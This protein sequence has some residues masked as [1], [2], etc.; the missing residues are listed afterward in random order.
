MGGHT[1]ATGGYVIDCKNLRQ[2]SFDPTT[3]ICVTVH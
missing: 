3:G 2:L 1:I